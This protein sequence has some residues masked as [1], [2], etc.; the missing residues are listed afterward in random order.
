VLHKKKPKP[1]PKPK[2]VHHPKPNQRVKK[3][4]AHHA[5]KKVKVTTHH[6]T[7]VV[8]TTSAHPVK[9]PAHV[10]DLALE[11]VHVNLRR[12]SSAKKHHG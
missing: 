3:T 8:V 1:K 2:P 11:D 6:M 12:S 4:V 9:P 5:P 10:V 7:K